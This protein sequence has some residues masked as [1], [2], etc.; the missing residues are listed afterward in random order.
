MTN[1]LVKDRKTMFIKGYAVQWYST[2]MGT[3]KIIIYV[4]IPGN[5]WVSVCED[6]LDYVAD[7]GSVESFAKGKIEEIENL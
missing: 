4:Q 7:D 1:G 6:A 2:L 5:R 3:T